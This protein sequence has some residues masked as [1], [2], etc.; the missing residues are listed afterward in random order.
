VLKAGLRR[1]ASPGAVVVGLVGLR[2]F[3]ALVEAALPRAEALDD[4]ADAWRMWADRAAAVVFERVMGF[5]VA[6]VSVVVFVE[7]DVTEPAD[8]GRG[9]RRTGAEFRAVTDDFARMCMVV[10]VDAALAGDGEAAILGGVALEG[11]GREG[12][13]GDGSE[14][15][16]ACL[17]G[18]DM[19]F[20]GG[21]IS[22]LV[23]MGAGLALFVG[24]A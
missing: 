5:L 19:V 6:V 18:V 23:V 21:R 2:G 7:V 9:G 20:G 4:G 22:L 8:G 1:G 14:E 12:V 10:R 11:E 15:A 3:A 16:G 17:E 24:S 13:V